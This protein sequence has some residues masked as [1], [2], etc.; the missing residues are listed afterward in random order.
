[1]AFGDQVQH[2]AFPITQG[3]GLPAPTAFDTNVVAG[4]LLVV[5]ASC[6]HKGGGAPTGTQSDW[7]LA[8][9]QPAQATDGG[10]VEVWWTIALASGAFSVTLNEVSS[11]EVL[12]ETAYMDEY[13]GPFHASILESTDNT[14][15][16]SFNNGQSGNSGSVTVA[17]QALIVAAISDDQSSGTIGAP[18]A[19][20]I[21]RF[22]DGGGGAY[23]ALAGASRAIASGGGNFSTTWPNSGGSGQVSIA[24]IAAFKG[25]GGGGGGGAEIMSRPRSKLP[26]R[27]FAP[28]LVR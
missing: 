6:Y 25:A 7:Q 1:M 27:P 23:N 5:V 9:M 13:A 10:H 2:K 12:F 11:N 3:S 22:S 28:R 21:E 24:V 14:A 18:T 8:A 16:G 26:P 19:S 17:D 4:N 20:F 15:T